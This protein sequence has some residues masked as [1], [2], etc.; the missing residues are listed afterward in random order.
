MNETDPK[1]GRPQETGYQIGELIRLAGS[2]PAAHDASAAR[3]KAAV[4]THWHGELAR[5]S[6]R[7]RVRTAVAFAF[8]TTLIGAVGTWVW[9]NFDT[10]SPAP[11][12]ARIEAVVGPVWMRTGQ[13]AST[14]SPVLTGLGDSVTV[15]TELATENR[16]RAAIR[17]ISGHSV[18]LDLGTRVRFLSERALALD[19]GAVYVDSGGS[20]GRSAESLTIRTPLG[21]VREIGTQFE[22]RLEHAAVQVRVR[23][24]RVTLDGRHGD[25]EVSAGAALEVDEQGRASRRELSG[26]GADWAWIAEITP[27]MELEGHSLREFLDWVVR[28][29]GL[30]LRF[31]SPDLA[32]SAAEIDLSGSIQGMTLDQAMEAVLPTCRMMHRIERDVL[33]V[34]R[35]ATGSGSS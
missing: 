17:M 27:L 33:F 34:E 8:A 3:V 13:S 31:A 4:R 2:P 28:E 21:V 32:D 23:E 15:G 35:L 30:K 14:R 10:E 22:V 16:G 1:Q 12:M 20:P 24:G 5:A 18:R 25:F 26:F 9:R 29:R 7:R 6:R 19:L 11:R